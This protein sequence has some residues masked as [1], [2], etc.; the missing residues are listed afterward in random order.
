MYS[1]PETQWE[2]PPDFHPLPATSATA[3]S[4]TS[5]TPAL[6][7]GPGH[8]TG[9]GSEEG[10]QLAGLKR[11]LEETSETSDQPLA[12]RAA[13]PYGGWTTVAIQ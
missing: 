5:D 12:K 6:G 10:G 1:P 8:T 9:G 7:S 4:E 2:Q 3:S 11:T 13:G